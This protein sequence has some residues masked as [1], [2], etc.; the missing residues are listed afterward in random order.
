MHDNPAL[1]TVTFDGG[2]IPAE[3]RIKVFAQLNPFY[4]VRPLAGLSA[5][6]FEVT[7]RVWLFADLVVHTSRITPIEIE[8]T[9]RH[10]AADGRDTYSFI[11]MREGGWSGVAGGREIQVGTGQVAVMDFAGD[12]RVAGTAQD[13]IF[14]VVPRAALAGVLP[15]MPA[16]HGRT[17][18]GAGGRLLAEYMLAL[19]RHLPDMTVRDAP[20]VREATMALIAGAVGQLSFDEPAPAVAGNPRVRAYIE[21]HLTSADLDVTRICRDLNMSRAALYRSFAGAGGIAAYI[22][23]RRLEAAHARIADET[24]GT[25]V[26]E[27][28]ETYRFSS[29]AHFTTAFR[30]HFG[31]TPREARGSSSRRGEAAAVF[32]RWTTMLTP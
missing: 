28:A 14:L 13:N 18:D 24:D 32:A 6:D 30:R 26:A 19:A 29:H 4:D 3:A 5:A 10:R 15:H 22:W 2:S 8:R 31:Y 12:W 21:Q 27:V 25:R 11:L 9:P 20:I 16:L 17:L 7:T 23:R 1:P